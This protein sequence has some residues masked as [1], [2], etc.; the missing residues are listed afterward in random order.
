MGLLKWWFGV[1]GVLLGL[2][3]CYAYVPVVL[4]V[5][6]IAALLGGVTVLVVS[7]ARLLERKLGRAPPD[8]YPRDPD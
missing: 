3:F 2:L 6:A 5:L 1:S 8:G 7:A 4:P